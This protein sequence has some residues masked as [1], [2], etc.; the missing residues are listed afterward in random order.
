VPT[1]ILIRHADVTGVGDPPLNAAGI[2]RAQE[3]RHV[4][5]DSDLSAIFVTSRSRSQM[6]AAPIAADL[7]IT[8]TVIDDAALIAE[9]I[10]AQP[11]S[12]TVLVVGHT[13]SLPVLVTALGGPA[14]TAIGATQ[15]DRLF[16]L[17]RGRLT[18]LRYGA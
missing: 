4:L 14:L 7:G 2:A 1:T 9:A 18:R 8:P 5:A 6:T 17:H 15:F 13:D 3:L 10:R 16:V 12:A 11:G